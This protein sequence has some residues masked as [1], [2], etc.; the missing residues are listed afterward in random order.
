MLYIII[1]FTHVIHLFI[2]NN[3]YFL[4]LEIIYII[5]NYSQSDM[6]YINVFITTI[7]I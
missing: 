4:H 7:L 5:N 2:I 3:N 1:Y 6:Q